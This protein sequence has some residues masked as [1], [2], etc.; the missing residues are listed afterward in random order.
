MGDDERKDTARTGPLV[1]ASRRSPTVRREGAIAIG[2]TAVGV[3]ALGAIAFGTLGHRQ[4]R[5]WAVKSRQSE[6]TQRTGRRLGYRTA[7]HQRTDDRTR[8]LRRLSSD[9]KIRAWNSQ[10]LQ[11]VVPLNNPSRT[12]GA[13]SLQNCQATHSAGGRRT[14]CLTAVGIRRQRQM[15]PNCCRRMGLPIAPSTRLGNICRATSAVV[16]VDPP[17]KIRRAADD[18]DRHP[19]TSREQRSD[20]WEWRRCG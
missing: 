1:P 20:S 15:L 10:N 12:M 18:C 9:G 11:Y 2:A 6:R 7:D 8:K 19:A 16:I 17:V 4:G 3:L 13:N 14:T 5:D